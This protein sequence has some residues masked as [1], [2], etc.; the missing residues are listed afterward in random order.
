MRP[1]G[2]HSQ[3]KTRDVGRSNKTQWTQQEKRKKGTVMGSLLSSPPQTLLCRN[4][5]LRELQRSPFD[6]LRPFRGWIGPRPHKKKG[7]P[8]VRLEDPRDI[9]CRSPGSACR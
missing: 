2:A 8:G 5:F 9:F 6:V 3:V 4:S 7:R 1:L